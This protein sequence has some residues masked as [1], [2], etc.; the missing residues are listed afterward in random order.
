[1]SDLTSDDLAALRVPLAKLPGFDP[2][3]LRVIRPFDDGSAWDGVVIGV[4][5]DGAAWL[6]DAEEI[7][8]SYGADYRPS[9]RWEVI[10]ELLV[11]RMVLREDEIFGVLG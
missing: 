5:A 2:V 6:G 8:R 1:M 11:D 9:L 7:T 3:G 4:D 10:D